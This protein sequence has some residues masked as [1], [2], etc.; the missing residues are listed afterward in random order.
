[1]IVAP[2]T[3]A[4][5]A[6]T[7]TAVPAVAVELL[8]GAVSETEVAATAVTEMAEEVT[9]APVESTTRAVRLNVAFE[10]G[11]Q[12]IEYGAE[13][14]APSKVVPAKNCT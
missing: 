4:A 13:L 14:S 12:V 9:V 8:A 5:D 2:A 11:T 6:V 7:V 10:L 1:V 3:G